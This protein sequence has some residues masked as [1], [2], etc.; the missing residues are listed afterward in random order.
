MRSR[1]R[2]PTR[3]SARHRALALTLGLGA[4]CLIGIAP[5]RS[6]TASAFTEVRP[7]QLDLTPDQQRILDKIRSEPAAAEIAVVRSN[8]AELRSGAAPWPMFSTRDVDRGLARGTGPWRWGNDAQLRSCPA[9]SLGYSGCPRRSGHRSGRERWP[10]LHRPTAR[11]RTPRPRHDR[12]GTLPA[13]PSR[14]LQSA[15]AGPASAP[16][17]PQRRGDVPAGDAAPVIDVLVAYTPA[18]SRPLPTPTGWP[19]SPSTR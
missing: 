6:Q 7:A 12:R 17:A 15:G 10:H 11:P 18:V 5:A 13:R 4:A 3:N 19:N 2:C 8:R 9:R 16:P 14:E 1:R